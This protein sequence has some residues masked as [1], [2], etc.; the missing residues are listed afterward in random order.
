MIIKKAPTHSS[1]KTETFPRRG[2]FVVHSL[3]SSSFMSGR[4]RFSVYSLAD[5]RKIERR[6]SKQA[7]AAAT[8]NCWIDGAKKRDLDDHTAASSKHDRWSEDRPMMD[9][10]QQAQKKRQNR[11]SSKKKQIDDG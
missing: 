10:G 7:A 4:V 5:E 11:P 3:D 2:K 6:D 8:T 9:T 1:K